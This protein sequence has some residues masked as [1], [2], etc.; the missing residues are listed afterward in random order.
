MASGSCQKGFTPR[1]SLEGALLGIA[2]GEKRIE[3][4]SAFPGCTFTVADRSG[5]SFD[6]DSDPDSDSDWRPV[7][8]AREL[9][10]MAAIGVAHLD[11]AIW[12]IL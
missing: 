9:I 12:E 6:S 5:W 7:P 2:V 11:A 8:T 4:A 10:E 1:T 3:V